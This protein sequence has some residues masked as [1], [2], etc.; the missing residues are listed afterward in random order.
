VCGMGSGA[1]GLV[2][3]RP[4]QEISGVGQWFGQRRA[5]ACLPMARKDPRSGVC[6]RMAALGFVL[7]VP[8][9][10][11]PCVQGPRRAPMLRYFRA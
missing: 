2:Q 5:N 8:H 3:T 9:Y 10:V 1:S 4:Q 11:I 6:G 7:D